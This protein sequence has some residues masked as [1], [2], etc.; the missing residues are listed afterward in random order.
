MLH[1][2][3]YD[4]SENLYFHGNYLAVLPFLGLGIGV[5]SREGSSDRKNL[6]SCPLPV[7]TL[8]KLPPRCLDTGLT[9][10]L[11]RTSPHAHASSMMSIQG[12]IRDEL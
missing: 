6:R 1:V 8:A 5:R 7:F 11:E 9:L 3:A 2:S 10:T 12:K 4:G